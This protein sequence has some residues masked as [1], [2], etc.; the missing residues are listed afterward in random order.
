MFR[1]AP[2]SAQV[3]SARSRPRKLKAAIA[4][5]LLGAAALL[6]GAFD[7]IAR[8]S[9]GVRAAALAPLADRFPRP[10]IA[11]AD[12]LT[13]LVVLGGHLSRMQEAIRLAQR[14]PDAKVLV[15][16]AGAA[17]KAFMRTQGLDNARLLFEDNARNTFENA[18][19]SKQLASPKSGER[20]LLI[21]SASHMPRAMG[22]FARM[23]FAVEPWPVHDLAPSSAYAWQPIR[24]E[25]LGLLAYRL[26]G[27]TTALFPAPARASP[28][29]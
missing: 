22:S 10:D 23:G 28:S 26:M 4:A 6:A 9:A 19:F 17:E 7:T 5:G 8:D 21:T 18:Q 20:W 12:R 14:H 15:T 29:T 2:G 1:G 27:R 11:P 13:G 16:G 24:H 25:W 3:E